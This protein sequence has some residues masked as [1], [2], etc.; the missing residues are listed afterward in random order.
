MTEDPTSV[1]V[2]KVACKCCRY[3]GEYD[4]YLNEPVVDNERV[5]AHLLYDNKLAVYLPDPFQKLVWRMEAV[6]PISYCPCCG[7]KLD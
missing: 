1:K 5:H 4:A 2:A 7:R 6:I 3:H